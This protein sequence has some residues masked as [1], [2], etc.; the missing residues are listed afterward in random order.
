MERTSVTADGVGTLYVEVERD[1]GVLDRLGVGHQTPL[2]AFL[3]PE[4]GMAQLYADQSE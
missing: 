1:G 3:C 2:H 4:C